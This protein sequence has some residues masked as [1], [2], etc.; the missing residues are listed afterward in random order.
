[1]STAAAVRARA[2]PRQGRPVFAGNSIWGPKV[3]LLV[4][5]RASARQIVFANLNFD[6]ETRRSAQPL[7][8]EAA[9]L[10]S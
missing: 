8:Q 3:G 6:T 2:K 4:L 9:A 7:D 1:M 10:Q 5:D